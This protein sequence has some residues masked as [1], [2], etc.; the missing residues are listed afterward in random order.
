MLI[1]VL[2]F[3]LRVCVGGGRV[4]ETKRERQRKRESKKRET[5][6]KMR[7]TERQRQMTDRD[8]SR[9]QGLVKETEMRTQAVFY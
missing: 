2:T 9:D 4:A 7:Q 6:E 3:V 5:D 1:R 8:F